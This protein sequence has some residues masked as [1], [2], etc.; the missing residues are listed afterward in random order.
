MDWYRTDI[1]YQSIFSVNFSPSPFLIT[2]IIISYNNNILLKVSVKKNW[3]R[4][5]AFSLFFVVSIL[6]IFLYS[7]S[8][9]VNEISFEII[10]HLS[11]I[12]M[13]TLTVLVMGVGIFK[14]VEKPMKL[15]AYYRSSVIL[16]VS[17]WIAKYYQNLF[18]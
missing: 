5:W 8:N 16:D 3:K 10:G 7:G 18:T 14:K 17:Y 12:W 11:M 6:I 9:L 4:A 2:I 1:L 15:Q 13:N